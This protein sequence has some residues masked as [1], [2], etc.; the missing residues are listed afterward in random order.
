[1]S[2]RGG[3]QLFSRGRP[4]G[5]YFSK[6]LLDL[7]S[8]PQTRGLCRSFRRRDPRPERATAVGRST[9][10]LARAAHL[11]QIAASW[12]GPVMLGL[13]PVVAQFRRPRCHHEHGRDI[14]TPTE[15]RRCT[16][17]PPA[18]VATTR[19][20]PRC[21]DELP[22]ARM[23]RGPASMISLMLA[24]YSR[25]A[26]TRAGRCFSIRKSPALRSG[27]CHGQL[28]RTFSIR[29]V[30]APRADLHDSVRSALA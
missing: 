12:A 22:V 8:H 10:P 13:V 11:D 7:N 6:F 9:V 18:R 28:L 5:N 24:S 27:A 29:S 21:L 4:C 26:P 19:L 1:M 20:K 30:G 16:A 25:S 15:S 17:P 14:Q 23:A 3:R 2:L